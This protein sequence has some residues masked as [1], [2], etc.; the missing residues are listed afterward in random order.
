MNFISQ[1]KTIFWQSFSNYL[2]EWNK[3]IFLTTYLFYKYPQR[4]SVDVSD[5]EL[6]TAPKCQKQ[7]LLSNVLLEMDAYHVKLL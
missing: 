5:F 1:W 3:Y 6:V 7:L 4:E 2:T